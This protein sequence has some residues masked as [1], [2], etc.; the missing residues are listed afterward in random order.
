MRLLVLSDLH[1]E[2]WH[3]ANAT[4]KAGLET[5]Q[6]DL[7]V[8]QPDIIVL[9]GD[10]EVG[11]RAVACSHE[12]FSGLPVIYV[13]GSHEGYGHNLDSL[14]REL[15]AACV[16]TGHIHYLER[17][18]LILEGV[19]FLGATLW[20]DCRHLGSDHYQAS[21]AEA[22]TRLSDYRRIR[23]AKGGYRRIRPMDTVQWHSKI[24]GG[25]SKD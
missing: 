23:L 7:R 20:T 11:V 5:I 16:A 25:L 19:R 3:D 10:I 9:A 18:E 21:M 1:S 2:V 4:A 15:G 8:S 14:K 22:S 12:A 6:P 17:R 13:P 24:D